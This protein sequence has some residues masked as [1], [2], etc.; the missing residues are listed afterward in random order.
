MEIDSSQFRS[1][2]QEARSQ[3][4]SAAIPY[5]CLLGI[6]IT[7][8][9]HQANMTQSEL[10]RRAGVSQSTISRIELGEGE[11]TAAQLDALATVLGV[12]ASTVFDAA[13]AA[14]SIFKEAEVSVPS[15]PSKTSREAI[16]G[17]GVAVAGAILGGPIGLLA[18]SIIG[19]LLANSKEN[20]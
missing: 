6:A 1:L 2:L 18:G 5:T 12:R 13:D 4:G 14:R 10:S 19:V 17:A 20:E 15:K 7:T 11:L 8:L 16:T 9:R 3:H